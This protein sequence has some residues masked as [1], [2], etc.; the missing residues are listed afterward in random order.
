MSFTTPALPE[1][2]IIYAT[3]LKPGST[4]HYSIKNINPGHYQ[5][6]I[7]NYNGQVVFKKDFILQVNFV[8]DNFKLPENMQKGMYSLQIVNPFYTIQKSFLVN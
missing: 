8:D 4:I 2:L 6:R 3:P 5:S 1:G 7:L